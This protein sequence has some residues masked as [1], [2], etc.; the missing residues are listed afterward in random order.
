M[1]ACR[2]QV[3]NLGVC[4]VHAHLLRELFLAHMSNVS[5]LVARVEGVV[6]SCC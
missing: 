6:T 4:I 2:V 3:Q 5:S 1:H